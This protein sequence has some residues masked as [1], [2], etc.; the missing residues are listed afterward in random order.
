VRYPIGEPAATDELAS[1]RQRHDEL[2]RRLDISSPRSCRRAESGAGTALD[3]SYLTREALS[4]EV[5]PEAES[6]GNSLVEE[7]ERS[8]LWS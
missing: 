4:L 7:S 6:T 1:M 2:V 8:S 3:T 5:E